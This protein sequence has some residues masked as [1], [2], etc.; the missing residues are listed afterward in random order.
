MNIPYQYFNVHGNSGNW[1]KQ[2]DETNESKDDGSKYNSLKDPA[3]L[4]D[5]VAFFGQFASRTEPF[6]AYASS[7]TNES[8]NAIMASKVSQSR[9]YSMFE[10]SDSRL[11]CAVN[12]KN[13]GDKYVMLIA[14]QLNMSSGSNAK[15]CSLKS[16]GSLQYPRGKQLEER[17]VNSNDDDA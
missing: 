4:Q 11:A 15:R 2:R 17:H 9:Y 8:F 16:N 13:L 3:S 1:Y 10:S 6:P 12:Q 5:L 14:K 7:Q